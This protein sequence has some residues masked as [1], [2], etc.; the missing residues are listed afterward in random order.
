MNRFTKEEKG[1]MFY[2]WAASAYSIIIS[3]AVF[4]LFYKASATNAGISSADSTAYLG[5]TISFAT[6]LLAI[7][8]PILGTIA[9]Y[10]GFKK[11]FF[12]FF[13]TLGIIFTASLAF[14][15]SNQWL[16][17]IS[18]LY[19]RRSSGFPE[20]IFSM[21][22]FL[23]MSQRKT[24]WIGCPHADSVWGISEVLFRLLSASPLLF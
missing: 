22:P 20:Q 11:R 13:F 19:N 5:Y 12:T 17:L 7:L 24:G 14:V 2:D 3:T 9:D 18:I 1:W 6:F 15:P 4:P 8:S 21:M 16:L 10:Q 23:L